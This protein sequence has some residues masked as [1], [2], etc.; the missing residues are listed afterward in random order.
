M[1]LVP[2]NQSFLIAQFR[3]FYTEVI[4]L[5]LLINTGAQIT[6]AAATNVDSNDAAAGDHIYFPEIDPVEFELSGAA[7]MSTSL[8]LR[9]KLQTTVS[10][11]AGVLPT[12][13]HA[14]ADVFVW[15]RL[16]ALFQHQALDALRHGGAY[17]E[18][19]MEA[20]YVMVSFAD[21]VFLHME[22]EGKRAWMS[23]LLESRI[24]RSH[25][26]GELLFEKLDLLLRE[27][28]PAHRSLATVY[29]MVLSLGF[30]GKYYGAKDQG[31][32][33]RY[34]Q[35]LFAFIFRREADPDGLAKRLFPDAY[36]HNLRKQKGK[37][38]ANPRVWIGV[39]CFVIVS[40]L[41]FSH[42]VWWHLTSRLE[43]VNS[44]ILDLEKRLDATTTTK[45]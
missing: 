5:K 38:L 22:W 29:L 43:A 26:A 20:Q 31:Q 41:A 12:A 10:H 27:R 40:Y 6:P 36:A 24:F 17:T 18:L 35:E 19:Y 15:Q 2:D 25:V 28:N 3:E 4:R 8:A 21:E 45:Q 14:S 44:Q 23:K 42:G 7:N 32:L 39:L 33:H 9:R 13:D 16:L 1:N 37:R 30:R 11:Q 34:R